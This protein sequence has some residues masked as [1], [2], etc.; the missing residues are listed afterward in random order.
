MNTLNE[1][2]AVKERIIRK[3]ESSTDHREIELLNNHYIIVMS[4]IFQERI[5]K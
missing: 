1:L 4:M 5:K 3:L 2:I